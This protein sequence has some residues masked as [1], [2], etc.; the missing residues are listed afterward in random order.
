MVHHG[1]QHVLVVGD[2]E[3]PRPQRDLGGQIETGDAPQRP[4]ASASR[5]AGQPAASTTCQPKSARST[6]TTRCCGIPS[7]AGNSVRRLSWRPTTSASAAPNAS[8]SRRPL[9]RNATAML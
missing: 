9:S 7:G 3:Q 6:G 1:H 5:S 8:A 2:A 4:T